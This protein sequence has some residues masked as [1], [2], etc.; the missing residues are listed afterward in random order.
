ML[1]RT[2]ES[3]VQEK[4]DAIAK[5]ATDLGEACRSIAHLIKVGNY[6]NASRMCQETAQELRVLAKDVDQAS[7]VESAGLRA[8]YAAIAE[9][10]NKEKAP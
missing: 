6:E 2:I 5:I 3:A 9:A 7:R 10:E 4:R 8:F 1:A